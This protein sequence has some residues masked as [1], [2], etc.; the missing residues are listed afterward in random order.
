MVQLGDNNEKQVE[1][2]QTMLAELYIE[3]LFKIQDKNYKD[4]IL[5][6]NLII[7]R[8]NKLI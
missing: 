6:P 8:R 3:N 2:Y 5:L 4:S 7:P 1:K